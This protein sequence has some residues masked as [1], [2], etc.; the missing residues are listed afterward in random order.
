MIQENNLTGTIE[1]K[2]LIARIHLFGYGIHPLFNSPFFKNHD[3][4][5]INN[6]ITG[7]LIYAAPTLYEYFKIDRIRVEN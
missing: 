6:R 7:E 3:I 5:A 1:T 4:V 2:Y